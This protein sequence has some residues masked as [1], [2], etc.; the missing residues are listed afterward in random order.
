MSKLENDDAET[1]LN[2][3]YGEDLRNTKS[4]PRSEK[5]ESRKRKRKGQPAARSSYN[6]LNGNTKFATTGNRQ[7]KKELASG[8]IDQVDSV[9]AGS[10]HEEIAM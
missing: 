8:R 9:L 7:S 3:A 6:P 4:R 10:K 5:S 2:D 1:V